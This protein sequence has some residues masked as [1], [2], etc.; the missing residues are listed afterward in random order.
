MATSSNRDMIFP[1][2]VWNIGLVLFAIFVPFVIMAVALPIADAA[3]LA[4]MSTAA[5]VLIIPGSL[6]V[7]LLILMRVRARLG[8]RIILA[9]PYTLAITWLLTISYAIVALVLTCGLCTLMQ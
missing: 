4:L 7:G 1:P 2:A 3:G 9:I 5:E 6:A 8:V